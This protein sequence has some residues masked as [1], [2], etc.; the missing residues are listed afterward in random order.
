VIELHNVT[1]RYDSLTAVDNIS[2]SIPQGE[3][4]G[5]LGPNGAGKTTLFK[6]IA[7]FLNPDSGQIRPAATRDWPRIGY[8][9]ERLL[10]PNHLRVRQ[11]LQ[12]VASLS[13]LSGQ[14]A[15]RAVADSLDKVR[16]TESAGKKIS[17]CSKGMRQRL[18]LAQT[19]I[20]NPS[21][22][23]LDE[24][25]NGLDPEGQDEICRR[26]QEL[27]AQGKTIVLAS[28][29]LFEVTQICTRLIIL[30]Q[31]TI[32]YENQIEGA[33]AERPNATIRVDKS[34]EPIKPL[35]LSLHPEIEINENEVILHR[36]A[37]TLRG[38]SQARRL[39]HRI[40]GHRKGGVWR[41]M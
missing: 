40:T 12:L 23:L 32:H 10:F 13:N 18:G 21:L 35:L 25:S 34:L 24:P 20:G 28:H 1:K 26:I 3:V 19:L 39:C 17:E 27:H 29:Q 30:K 16:L 33:L 22:F 36:E 11:Y 14:E 31:G 5:I 7:G 4:V 9:P 2:L 41:R 15:D 8:K 38:G 37:M 6:L